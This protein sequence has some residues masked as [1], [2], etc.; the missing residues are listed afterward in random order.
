MRSLALITARGG[1]KGIPGK[2][3]KP[4]NGKPLINYTIEV[5][6][7]VFSATDI[8]LSTDSEAIKSVA[9]AAGLE[10]PFLRPSH[11]ATD[12]AGSY[13]VIL[14]ALEFYEQMGQLYDTVVLLQPTS[15]LRKAS[16]ITE[17]M[18]LFNPEIDM[19]VSVKETEANPYYI[20]AEEN[21]EGYLRRSK[22]GEFTRRQDV[23]KVWEYNG[24]IY[25]INVK[26]LKNKPIN[27]FEKVI[28]YVMDSQDS[29]DLDT[30]M[31]WNFL[32]YLFQNK[33]VFN[34]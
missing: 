17:A 5:A 33:L 16:H 20:L 22:K 19:V 18:S 34:G 27:Q 1:S 10:V 14:H 21:E 30:P 4:L 8:C 31:D 13:E 25:V 7:Q 3:I 11:L 28:K 23:P 29:I 32:E 26:S 6:Q 24:A 15:P 2:N 12:A 9:E